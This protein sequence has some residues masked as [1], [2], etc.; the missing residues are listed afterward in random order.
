TNTILLTNKHSDNQIGSLENDIRENRIYSATSLCHWDIEKKFLLPE[1]LYPKVDEQSN[2]DLIN[3]FQK[4]CL[5]YT[6][7]FVFDYLSIKENTLSY[8]LNAYKTFVEEIITK[9]IKDI[10]IEGN[11][12]DLFY[13]IYQWIYMGG[14]TNDTI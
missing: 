10:N 6:T 4:T 8:K 14:N 11:S 5:L 13:K 12:V 1:D 2:P 7:M 3:V 9:K